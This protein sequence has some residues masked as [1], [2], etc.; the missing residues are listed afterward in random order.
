MATFH[1]VEDY[2]R[3]VRDLIRQHPIDEAM[4]LAVG[5]SYEEIG[6]IEYAIL[7]YAGLTEG[8]SVVDLGCGSGRLAFALSRGLTVNYT[9]LDVVQPLLDYAISKCPKSYRFILN[10]ALT[11]PLP[12]AS[13]DL[14]CAFSVFTHLLQAE[15]YLYL[16]DMHRCL[17]PGG[18][19]VLSFLEFAMP[20]HWEP[21]S[22]TV[23]TQRTR[24]TPHLNQFIERNQIEVW[25]RHLGYKAPTFVDG[26]AAPWPSGAALGQSI[27]ILDRA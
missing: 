20:T 24:T 2:E 10:H 14:C 25:A 8:Q 17:V 16:Q 22:V 1:F 26:T 18:R 7:R 12:D 19:V 4:S 21:F 3:V 27:A 9:G 5:G 13:T 11:L 6:R 23:E 15:T